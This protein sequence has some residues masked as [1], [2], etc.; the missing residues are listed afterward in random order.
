MQSGAGQ[1]SFTGSSTSLSAAHSPAQHAP[2]VAGPP[3][4]TLTTPAVALLTLQ[5][6]SRVVGCLLGRRG[7]LRVPTE[8]AN[9]PAAA[10]AGAG[11]LR[12][13][14]SGRALTAGC[15]ALPL[16]E[17]A[18]YES[19]GATAWGERASKRGCC[20]GTRTRC[21]VH[22]SY[23]TKTLTAVPGTAPR[24]PRVAPAPQPA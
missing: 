2:G 3:L 23:S 10:A 12:A 7:K 20:H 6:D 9:P 5:A 24:R 21:T 15:R 22:R 17:G 8:A 11:R 16:L 13:P 18:I 14:V 1:L 4:P 19:Q